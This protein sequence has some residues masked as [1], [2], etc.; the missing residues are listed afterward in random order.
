[1][2]NI[3]LSASIAV[4]RIIDGDTLSIW[5]TTN[6]IPLHQGLNPNDFSATP[7]W[8]E[9]GDHPEI[10]PHVALHVR[11]PFL[12]LHTSGNTIPLKSLSQVVQDG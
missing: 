5:F 6:G 8:T 3:S 7:K 12:S 11:M 9:S 2:D 10:T 1:M 4:R